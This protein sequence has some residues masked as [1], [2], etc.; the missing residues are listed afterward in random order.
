MDADSLA[1]R[2]RSKNLDEVHGQDNAVAIVEGMFNTQKV[3]TSILITGP[4]GTGKTTLAK[5]IGHRLNCA[6]GTLCGKCI[7]CQFGDSNPD[8]IVHNAGTDGG[9]DAIRKLVASSRVSPSFRKRVIVVDETHRLTGASL[10]ALLLPVEQGARKTL[11]ILC[12]TDPEKLKDS[13]KGRCLKLNLKSV[14]AEPMT[15]RLKEIIK[16]EDIKPLMGKKGKAAIEMICNISNGSLREAI[17]QVEALQLAIASG[18]DFN[19]EEALSAIL[20]SGDV[21]LDTAAATLVG[22]M[23]EQDLV[24]AITSIRQASNARGMVSKARWLADWLIAVKTKTA[25][26][27]PYAGRLFKEQFPKTKTPLWFLINIQAMFVET[28]LRMNSCSIDEN[29]LLSSAVG[30]LINEAEG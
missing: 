3:P 15:A 9:I 11:W 30:Q 29:V 25:K 16:A 7:S 18:R 4:T 21:D 22:A 28:E 12:T 10:E 17:S 26:F 19:T 23:L 13:L 1:T 27:T 8:V 20:T 24:K 2:W 6:K 5:I 14:A